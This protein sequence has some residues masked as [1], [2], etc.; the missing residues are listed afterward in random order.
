MMVPQSPLSTS[1]MLRNTFVI[2]LFLPL[3]CYSQIAGTV[4]YVSDG[5]TFHFISEDGEKIKVRVADI[6]CPERTQEFGLEAKEFTLLEIADKQVMLVVKDTDR[7][8]RKVSFVKYE[9]KDL[10]E[11]LLINGLAWHYKKYST[12]QALSELEA[13][14]RASKAGLWHSATPVPP[15]EYRKIQKK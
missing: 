10:S 11:Q 7:Y 12:L 8:G 15:W 2:L 13:A 4:S 5:D 6:D 1:K 14:A 9:G 3:V